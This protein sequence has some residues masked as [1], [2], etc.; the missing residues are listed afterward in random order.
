MKSLFRLLLA[1]L[2]PLAVAAVVFFHPAASRKRADRARPGESAV[3]RDLDLSGR[4][5]AENRA[6][7]AALAALEREKGCPALR[8]AEDDD[9]TPSEERSDLA[10]LYGTYH[11]YFVR[12]DLNGDGR[13]DFAQ[14]FVDKGPG[15]WFHVAVFLGTPDGGFE[16]PIWVER[17]VSLAAGDLSLERT[18]LIVVPDLSLDESRRWRW[19]GVERRFVDAD[20]IPRGDA[21]DVAADEKPRLR[22]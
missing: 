16:A 4:T 1:F 21:D 11:P 3:G 14:G 18:L 2:V 8:V 20:A 15:G 19:D 9:A 17:G 5:P 10:D 6:I 12:G 22:I 13:P 7:A